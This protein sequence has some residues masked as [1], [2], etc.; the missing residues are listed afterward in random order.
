[1][2]KVCIIGAGISGLSAACFAA[3]QGHKVTV[4]EKNATIGGRGRQFT[5]E[6]FV[7]DIGPSWYWMPDV[8][9][10]FYNN[11]G[12]TTSDF[13][14]LV[15]IEP[16]FRIFFGKGDVLDVPTNEDELNQVFEQI[17]PG[18]SKALKAY[19]DDGEFKYKEG[20]LRLAYMPGLSW[21]EFADAKLLFNASKLKMFTSISKHVRSYF[22]DPRL[23]ALMEFPVLFL[24]AMPEKTPALYS[25]M[26]FAALRQ[27]TFYPMGGM[28]HIFDAM[29]K[30]ALSL[31]VEFKTGC[32]VDKINIEAKKATSITTK[33][34]K[35]DT[36][37]IIASADYH[38]VEQAM[39]EPR[40]RN[41]TE[42]YWEKKTFAP[43]CLVFFLGLNKKIDNLLH[44]TLFFDAD[45][46]QLCKEIYETPKW[47]TDPL[48]Y[49]CCP[50]KTDES[51]A[52]PG[53]ENLFI[54]MPIATGLEDAPEQHDHYFKIVMDRMEH[55]CGQ[56]IRDA[57][58]YKKAYSVKDFKNDYNAYKGNGYG[59]ANTLKQTAVLKPKIANKKV[60]NLFYAGQLTVPGP[61]LPP[62]IISGQIAAEEIN[63][64]LQNK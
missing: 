26:N 22:K 16:G 35:F 53:H 7:F 14:D 58:V 46:G 5:K 33:E 54:L 50:S 32:P 60:G 10:K 36:D 40:Y 45:F 20:M 4:F 41:Y 44:H 29:H 21:M 59:L 48:F 57:V 42:A 27:G 23:V 30:I 62:G 11:F 63:K 13:Y 1:M 8:F 49:V 25:L 43:S 12:K 18:S 3:K 37:A 9:E 55:M 47:P 34:G 61:G 51:V 6:G 39:L 31:G 38:H 15:K 17:E 52:P 64:K 19:L 24:G 2:A 56:T 28:Y